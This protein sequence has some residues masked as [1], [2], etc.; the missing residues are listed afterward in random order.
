VSVEV[1]ALT[2]AHTHFLCVVQ[3]HPQ[4]VESGSR[5]CRL[6]RDGVLGS[7]LLIHIGEDGS[8]FPVRAGH[9]KPTAGFIRQSPQRLIARR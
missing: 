9:V 3:L 5:L 6:E 4:C 1:I 7:H 2:H 8:Q